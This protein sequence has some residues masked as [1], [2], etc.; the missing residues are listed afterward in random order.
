M[1]VQ[2]F[3]WAKSQCRAQGITLSPVNIR[4]VAEKAFKL[5]R[6]PTMTGTELATIVAPTGVFTDEEMAN[7][8]IS[9]HTPEFSLKPKLEFSA[10]PRRAKPE[11][12]ATDLGL[13]KEKLREKFI[14]LL[15]ALVRIIIYIR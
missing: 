1:F 5:L 13:K 8:F 7:F 15:T 10:L 6:I 11:L 12:T 9:V 4:K 14:R 2:L 3:R